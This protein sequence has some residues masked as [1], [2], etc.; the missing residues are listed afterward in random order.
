M[1]GVVALGELL[2]DFTSQRLNADGYPVLEAHPGGAP[3]NYL[4][5]LS[6]YG[7]KTALL[8]KV[9]QDVFGRLLQSTLERCGISTQGILQDAG[10]FTTLAFV[11]LDAD[12]DREFSF[13]RKPG[14]DTQLN[15][16]ELDLSL[17]DQA[18]V[19][20]FGTLSLTTEPTRSATIQA[21]EYAKKQ[22]RLISFDPNL[23]LPLWEDLSEAKHQILWGLSQADVIK[24]SAEEIAFLFDLAPEPGADYLLSNTAAQLV[25]VTLG[26]DGCI[27]AS[28]RATGRQANFNA[29]IKTVDT[30]GAGDIFGGSAMSRILAS[31][32]APGA[33]DQ[34]QLQQIAAFACAA[35]SLSTT[36][37]GGIMSV[38]EQAEVEA[39]MQAPIDR[40]RQA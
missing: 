34:A 31:G 9:G 16:S 28:H 40:R 24:I 2:I 20:H 17:I 39:L 29:G 6:K 37:Y 38:P 21:V 15:F 7:V 22:S 3:A 30:T 5:A 12:G 11:T 27:Y 23:R 4:A 36:R 18:D 25:F 32:M 13:A 33:L 35:A 8:A 1:S 10:Y 14:A 26:K 19:F